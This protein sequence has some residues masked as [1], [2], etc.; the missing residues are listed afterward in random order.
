MC[1]KYFHF[2]KIKKKCNIGASM[3]WWRVPRISE[4][5]QGGRNTNP[6]MWVWFG[7]K[8]NKAGLFHMGGE[9]GHDSYTALFSS[10]LIRNHSPPNLPNI[11]LY[12]PYKL[13]NVSLMR[14]SSIKPNQ[15]KKLNDPTL[16]AC[17]FLVNFV[18][19]II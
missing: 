13:I 16:S 8:A 5:V 1:P 12:I 9:G 11:P 17:L 3:K 4:K 18:P 6:P 7:D 19:I 2:Y 10:Q 14:S 15:G